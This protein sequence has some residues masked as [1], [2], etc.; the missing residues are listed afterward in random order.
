[1]IYNAIQMREAIDKLI[2]R[3]KSPRFTDDRY[4]EAINQ[5]SKM[6]LDDRVD[7]NKQQKGYS[8]QSNEKLRVELGSLVP[9]TFIATI[10]GDV[11]LFPT[12]YYYLLLIQ[13][14]VDGIKNACRPLTYNEKGL[15]N[16][17]PFRKPTSDETYYNENNAGW[18]IELPVGAS[19]T[20]SEIDY[21]KKPA[22]VTI[23]TEGNKV[24]PSSSALLPGTNYTV[25]NEA[26]MNGTTYYEGQNFN[27]NST[28]LTS[29]IVIRTALITDSDMPEHLHEDVIRLAAAIME[30]TVENYNKQKTLIDFNQI[31]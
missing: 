11:V 22:I 18:T 2:D 12:D 5:S 13:N 29:G 3:V 4:Y 26:I 30:G 6:I 8:V 31:S 24:Y 17:N 23:G 14:T 10:N 27:A 7:N 1:M 25:Y 28:T 20:K 21:I 15:I 16:R 9:P 19:F